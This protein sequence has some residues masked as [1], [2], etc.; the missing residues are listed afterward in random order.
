MAPL[1]IT[2]HSIV[3]PDSGALMTGVIGTLVSGA[4]LVVSTLVVISVFVVVVDF[5]EE[6]V[7]FFLRSVSLLEAKALTETKRTQKPN[8]EITR[9][10]T[11]T[12]H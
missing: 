7:G 12:S 9:L 8:N 10:S 2:C 3:S 5:V 4:I 11:C 6:V 1:E